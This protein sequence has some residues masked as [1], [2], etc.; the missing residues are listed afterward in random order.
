MKL[1]VLHIVCPKSDGPGT[2]VI[3]VGLYVHHYQAQAR[4]KE[5]IAARMYDKHVVL[6][7]FVKELEVIDD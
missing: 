1:W 4:G 5:L 2:Y 7:Y 6:N 3:T